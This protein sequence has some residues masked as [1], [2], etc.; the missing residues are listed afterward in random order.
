MDIV[1]ALT[2]ENIVYQNPWSTTHRAHL[3]VR[4]EERDWDVTHCSLPFNEEKEVDLRKRF[5]LGWEQTRQYYALFSKQLRQHLVLNQKI[6][7]SG[8]PKVANTTIA[9]LQRIVRKKNKDTGSDAYM[10]SEPATPFIGSPAMPDPNKIALSSVIGIGTRMLQTQ[11]IYSEIGIHMGIVDITSLYLRS[12]GKK[13]YMYNGSLLHG[14]SDG[15][16][17][18][19]HTQDAKAF[20]P[21]DV[22]EGRAPET[23]LTDAHAL[24]ALLWLLMSGKHYT[25][26]PD[27]GVRPK[28]MP[29]NVYDAITKFLSDE[30]EAN[31]SALNS[32][33]HQANKEIVSGAV[34]NI[35]IPLEPPEYLDNE[36]PTDD[37][38]D[39]NAEQAD[40]EDKEDE[41]KKKSMQTAAIIGVIL[42]AL[43][44]SFAALYFLGFFPFLPSISE[45]FATPTPEPTAIVTP[46]PTIA[47]TEAPV[48]KGT[49]KFYLRDPGGTPVA[50]AVFEVTDVTPVQSE[51]ES[52]EE[53]LEAEAAEESEAEADPQKT[54]VYESD[55][56]VRIRTWNNGNPIFTTYA[57]GTKALVNGEVQ[58]YD[59]AND[60][61]GVADAS[62][63]SVDDYVVFLNSDQQLLLKR[64]VGVEENKLSLTD[65][66]PEE[67]NVSVE[68]ASAGESNDDTQN[69]NTEAIICET[70]DDGV[71]WLEVID[72]HTY[73]M[74]NTQAGDGYK[75][76]EDKISYSLK[77][78]KLQSDWINKDLGGL[79]VV[80]EPEAHINDVFVVDERG[81]LSEEVKQYITERNKQLMAECDGAQVVIAVSDADEITAA[82]TAMTL[83]DE[84]KPGRPEKNN[85]IVVLLNRAS[86]HIF[87]MYQ[88]GA[89][90]G[91]VTDIFDD[92][93]L[94]PSAQSLIAAQIPDM[95]SCAMA[96]MDEKIVGLD[97]FYNTNVYGMSTNV[98]GITA[99]AV[100]TPEPTPEPT[101][102]PTPQPQQTRPSGG[103][104]GGTVYVEVPVQVTDPPMQDF[105]SFSVAPTY[106]ELA[107]GT[108]GGLSYDN[109][110]S[111]LP[112]NISS[113]DSSIASVYL[114]TG[115]YGIQV[116]AQSPGTCTIYVQFADGSSQNVTVVVR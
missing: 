78:G 51:A 60:V 56:S 110:N 100:P 28:F 20:M 68:E 18:R 29:D 89:P 40:T 6:F 30:T 91:E 82:N 16:A 112:P 33:L 39:P 103:G 105:G 108:S 9:V 4:D 97:R 113:S 111:L 58:T 48:M 46:E 21:E 73:S 72:G 62:D 80:C 86:Q 71:A 47:P 102:A 106:L 79:L 115:G 44:G 59:T 81:L 74:I 83:L 65:V 53:E 22:Y 42:A 13:L 95:N 10:F 75:L 54:V 50:G 57:A 1:D 67:M 77:G 76:I 114:S 26:V 45:L 25:S 70:D 52:E 101:P 12:D 37:D 92:V 99:E 35:L 116:D 109:G 88:V 8:N 15:D 85:G 19:K 84:L 66:S 38:P 69:E 94:A 3:L 11:K 24:C 5:M 104:G 27:F 17:P 61:I 43:I 87:S 49:I 31:L 2:N 41:S 96:A 107:A 7:E 32:A 98:R 14:S 34:K 63:I 93:M 64:V 55:D 90:W 36:Y 23:R